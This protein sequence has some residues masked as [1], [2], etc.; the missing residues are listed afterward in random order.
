[1]I[2]IVRAR[3]D[4]LHQSQILPSLSIN[5]KWFLLLRNSFNCLYLIPW[6]QILKIHLNSVTIKWSV[7]Q[8]FLSLFF[9]ASSWICSFMTKIPLFRPAYLYVHII[10]RKHSDCFFPCKTS[11]HTCINLMCVIV[12]Y[13][14]FLQTL[15]CTWE[16][17]SN[18]LFLW[19]WHP[20]YVHKS[21]TIVLYVHMAYEAK[22]MMGLQ[23]WAEVMG[24]PTVFWQKIQGE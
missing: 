21:Y 7:G 12:T 1:M 24:E 10:V 14:H 19:L 20:A 3:T 23:A 17:T 13:I 4:F 9:H 11:S 8:S 5:Q 16:F 22:H 6:L 2:K 18:C 15:S